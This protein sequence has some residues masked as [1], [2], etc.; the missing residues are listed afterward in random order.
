MARA[1]RL[2]L[3]GPEST[4]KTTLARGL[5]AAFGAPWTPEAARLVAEASPEPLSTRTVEPIARLALSLADAA[6][7]TA[8][9]CVIHDTDLVSTV[10]YA[11]HYYGTCPAWIETEAHARLSDGYLLCAPD[12]PWVADGIRDRADAR[13]TLLADFLATLHTFGAR[14]TLVGGTGAGRL[15]AARAAAEAVRAGV[16]RSR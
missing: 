2:T 3:I 9:R 15:A 11:R 7:A 12:L 1:T 8:A 10:V 16:S 4:G 6:T 5:A 13:R 14:V